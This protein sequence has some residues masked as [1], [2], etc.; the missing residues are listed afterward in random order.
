MASREH[1]LCPNCLLQT[2]GA[3]LR[4]QRLRQECECGTEGC[5]LPRANSSPGCAAHGAGDLVHYTRAACAML[6]VLTSPGNPC[7]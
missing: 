2:P 5:V 6:P 4:E 3:R 7:E 1:W